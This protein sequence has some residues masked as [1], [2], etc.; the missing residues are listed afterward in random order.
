MTAPHRLP[1]RIAG[2][3]AEQEALVIIG[4]RGG[5]FAAKTQ[6]GFLKSPE[7]NWFT[8]H[9]GELVFERNLQV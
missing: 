7:R 5:E 9:A 2:D 6:A 3:N 8:L 1:G 4:E